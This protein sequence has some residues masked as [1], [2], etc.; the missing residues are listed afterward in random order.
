MVATYDEWGRLNRPA[1]I[2]CIG[3]SAT[4]PM[5]STEDI[6][7]AAWN[8]RADLGEML[9]QAWR[10]ADAARADLAA[11][12]AERDA[13]VARLAEA[14]N[15]HTETPKPKPKPKHAPGPDEYRFTP[16]VAAR[17][18]EHIEARGREVCETRRAADCATLDREKRCHDCPADHYEEAAAVVLDPDAWRVD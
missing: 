3:C 17:V 9:A 7:R 11:V 5:E 8:R 6:A 12:I 2:Q 18:A 15:G 14:V 13:L 1:A 16:E 10:S 4:G